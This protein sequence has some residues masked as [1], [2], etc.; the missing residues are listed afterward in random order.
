MWHLIILVLLTALLGACLEL[1]LRKNFVK[2]TNAYRDL[3]DEYGKLLSEN[4]VLKKERFGL[5][6]RLEQIMALYDV[7]KQICKSLEAEKVF[8]Y[9]K[10]EVSKYIAISDCKFLN[11]APELPEQNGNIVVPVKIPNRPLAYLAA[12][13]I[14]DEDKI[15]FQI[16]SQQFM[17]GIKR[18]LLYQEVQELAIT[19][20]LTQVFS[21]R[22]YLERFAEEINRSKKFGY[23]FSCLMID[24]DH[25]KNYNDRYGHL[26]GDAILKELSKVIKENIRQIDLMGRYGGEEFSII[27]PETDREQARLAAERIRQAIE[28]RHIKA[29]DEDL[30][31]TVSM[32][33]SEFPKHGKGINQLIDSADSALYKAKQAGRNRVCVYS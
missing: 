33:V 20:G 14:K 15:T 11:E 19:D 32:G 18:A 29:Y 16:L 12:S 25:F 13:G 30:K 5:Q 6:K 21:R 24:I 31:I 4:E 1:G 2:R 26:V 17:L 10:E 9:F 7:T 8:V 27:L 28:E 3:N 22:Y 23:L